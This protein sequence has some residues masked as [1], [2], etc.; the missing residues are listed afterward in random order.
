MIG[1]V[2]PGLML[3]RCTT[4]FFGP[5]VCKRDGRTAGLDV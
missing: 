1:R 3:R 4:R 5:L 2:S